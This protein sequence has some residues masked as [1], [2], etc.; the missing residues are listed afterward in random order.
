M[1]LDEDDKNNEME[2]QSMSSAKENTNIT[3]ILK[4]KGATPMTH[5]KN[6]KPIGS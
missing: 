1:D 2:V 4:A 5:P 3:N 6:D